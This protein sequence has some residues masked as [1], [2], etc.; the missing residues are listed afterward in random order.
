MISFSLSHPEGKVGIKTIVGQPEIIAPLKPGPDDF[1]VADFGDGDE[2][3]DCSNLLFSTKALPKPKAKGKA[4]GK[5]K[6]KA[7]GKSKKKVQKKPVAAD[8]VIEEEVGEALVGSE[9]SEE[10]ADEAEA[11]AAVLE[12]PNAED[13]EIVALSF[14]EKK[15]KKM[16]L[17]DCIFQIYC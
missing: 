7:K 13:A 4:K 6:S 16:K 14:E 15:E 3:T 17:Q 5:A 9:E 12:A 10:E 11:P 2:V 1:C 8:A